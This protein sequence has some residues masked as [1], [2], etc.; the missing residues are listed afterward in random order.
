MHGG[1]HSGSAA[2]ERKDKIRAQFYQQVE[3]DKMLR[4]KPCSH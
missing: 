2:R 1:G 3:S 4:L